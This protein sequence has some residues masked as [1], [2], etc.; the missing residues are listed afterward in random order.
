MASDSD[1]S[2]SNLLGSAAR[3]AR[4]EPDFDDLLRRRRRLERRK[5]IGVIVTTVVALV[6][7]GSAFLSLSHLGAGSTASKERKVQPGSNPLISGRVLLQSGTSPQV[8]VPSTGQTSTLTTADP[9]AVYGFDPTGAYILAAVQESEPSGITRGTALV[10]V[11]ATT[12]AETSLVTAI[13]SDSLGPA[14][15]SPDG[16]KIAY[17]DTR[18]S[19]DPNLNFPGEPQGQ[20]L[21]SFI[22][23]TSTTGC[24]PQAG[25]VYDFD[26]HPNSGK[27]VVSGP[28]GAPVNLLDVTSGSIS[29]FLLPGGPPALLQALHDV[30]LGA[31]TSFGRPR[32][33][34]S[35]QYVAVEAQLAVGGVVPVVLDSSGAFVAV[36]NPNNDSQVLAWSPSQ[37]VLAYTTGVNGIDPAPQP[38][39]VY[40]LHPLTKLS[41]LLIDT[42]SLPN[43]S[44]LGLQ[45]SPSGLLLALDHTDRI[46]IVNLSG[47]VVD[48]ELITPQDMSEPLVGWAP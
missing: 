48:D 21:C 24:F 7:V 33:S 10:K 23:S 28:G 13:S 17:V 18:W 46:R 2:V 27:V 25:T 16:S 11:D 43:P 26:W 41:T 15:W 20:V 8:L 37:D 22:V 38:W 1:V 35:G 5:M 3:D 30:G 12:G 36:G 42:N 14:K 4:L 32:W 29:P 44:V 31:V 40:L 34:K 6:A 47:I 9:L 45:W 19:Q 39:R